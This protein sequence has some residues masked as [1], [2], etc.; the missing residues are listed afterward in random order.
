MSMLLLNALLSISLGL[1]QPTYGTH[2]RYPAV[3]A[4]DVS[5]FRVTDQELLYHRDK[6]LEMHQRFGWNGEISLKRANEQ[7]RR[8]I[9]WDRLFQLRCRPHMSVEH[10]LDYLNELYEKLGE[11]DYFSGLLPG[12]VCEDK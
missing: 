9:V 7:S 6:A 10:K 1:N 2:H 4:L 8:F 5:L 12:S 11:R 3:N